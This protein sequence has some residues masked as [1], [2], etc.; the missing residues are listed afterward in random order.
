MVVKNAAAAVVD[1]DY[2]EDS[3]SVR[4][5]LALLLIGSVRYDCSMVD[6]HCVAAVVADTGADSVADA[7]D[8]AVDLVNTL[9]Q[10][11]ELVLNDEKAYHHHCSLVMKVGADPLGQ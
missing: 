3:T 6:D 8:A 5:G 4:I 1:A 2:D 11:E 10:I 9:D 7:V